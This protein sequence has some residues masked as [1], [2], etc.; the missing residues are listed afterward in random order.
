MAPFKF[1]TLQMKFLRV[2]VKV[3]IL[4]MLAIPISAADSVKALDTYD[5]IKDTTIWSKPNSSLNFK[6][7]SD[8]KYFRGF[9]NKLHDNVKVIEKTDDGKWLKI[10]DIEYNK[11]KVLG[12]SRSENFKLIKRGIKTK[13][14]NKS[15]TASYMDNLLRGETSKSQPINNANKGSGNLD[16]MLRGLGEEIEVA[17]LERE[18]E[19]EMLADQKKL[20][21]QQA[22]IDLELRSEKRRLRREQILAEEAAEEQEEQR[23]KE[24]EEAAEENRRNRR[25]RQAARED[26]EDTQRRKEW[27]AHLG[28]TADELLQQNQRIMRDTDQ[29]FETSKKIKQQQDRSAQ[30]DYNRKQRTSYAER[31]SDNNSDYNDKLTRLQQNSNAKKKAL[32]EK[33]RRLNAQYEKRRAALEKKTAAENKREDDL[34]NR[35]KQLAADKQTKQVTSIN[36]RASD[37]VLNDIKNGTRLAAKNCFGQ[38]HVSGHRPK[39][40]NS[41]SCIDVHFQYWC[42]GSPAF[43]RSGILDKFVGLSA[44]CF[45]DI[46]EIEKINCKPKDI[47]VKVSR[48]T[49]CGE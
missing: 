35:Q 5:C 42:E 3:L 13:S 4:T 39:V 18:I 6:N 15:S 40:K 48:V 30:E 9:I 24:G 36:E 46:A 20:E 21:Q 1:Y 28:D 38:Y 49:E 12:Y 34:L 32:E 14:T 2:L 47:V 19:A 37:N 17:T 33:K 26:R 45:G 29:A 27:A 22:Q 43:K 41:P 11:I 10:V 8:Y 25:R 7:K 23:L 16:S 31:T 44:G